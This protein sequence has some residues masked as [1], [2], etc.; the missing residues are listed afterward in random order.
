MSSTQLTVSIY[1]KNELGDENDSCESDECDEFADGC[2]MFT[3]LPLNI[4]SCILL[5]QTYQQNILDCIYFI[6]TKLEANRRMQI[7]LRN[8]AQS[9]TT[10]ISTTL[11]TKAGCKHPNSII[12]FLAPYFKDVKGLHPP[13][14][15]DVKMKRFNGEINQAMISANKPWTEEEKSQLKILVEQQSKRLLLDPLCRSK[16]IKAIAI[17]NEPNVKKKKQY[18]EEIEILNLEIDRMNNNKLEEVA[19]PREASD[20]ID[21]LSISVLLQQSKQISRSYLACELIWTNYLHPDINQKAWTEKED[22]KLK[23]LI[24]ESGTN[25]EQIA[26]NLG[27]NRLAWQCFCRYQSELNDK[28]KRMGP[29]SKAEAK[30]VEEIVSQLRI[31]NFI[32]WQQVNYFIDGRKSSQIKHY[33]NKINLLKRGE[34]W[35]ELE[36]KVLTAAVTK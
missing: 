16:E 24:S 7:E 5:N 13:Q 32:P 10:T 33:W 8:D 19:P 23:Q 27:T 1:E 20:R 6:E 34:S 30:K 12:P 11:S 36:D 14:N 28:M 21:W 29:L 31:G 2:D 15:H 35:N 26:E 3:F 18:E 22:D 17:R 25:W 9:T 4:Y